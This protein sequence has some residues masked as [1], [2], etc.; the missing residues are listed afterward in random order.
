MAFNFTNKLPVFLFAGLILGIFLLPP[1]ARPDGDTVYSVEVWK[2]E[3]RDGAFRTFD[4]LVSWLPPEK[5]DHLRIEL[6]RGTF[7]L[8]VGK[9]T[10]KFQA[11]ELIAIVA[12]RY[13]SA[14]L[15]RTRY[16]RSRLVKLYRTSHDAPVGAGLP[17]TATRKE[18]KP[19]NLPPVAQTP[20]PSPPDTKTEKTLSPPSPVAHP[21]ATVFEEPEKEKMLA[22]QPQKSP[23]APAPPITQV[24]SPAK[25]QEKPLPPVAS[26]P[27]ESV[28]N[29][30][31]PSPEQK[32]FTVQA[33]SFTT[34]K[35]AKKYYG[36][37]EWHLPPAQRKFLRIERVKGYITVRVGCFA[38]ES[39][40]IPLL[41]RVRELEKTSHIL[42][43]HILENRI[44][45]LYREP[46]L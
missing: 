5:R 34:M 10:E 35:Q 44:E 40:A 19:E 17:G 4:T 14:T 16:D 25:P 32:I 13:S 7:A 23:S 20:P 27:E 42:S 3:T 9:F 39:A 29:P 15:V 18:L 26:L 28:P 30:E 22:A 24:L 31:L 41:N 45:Q 37:L 8:R 21:P 1:T 12:E 33:G 11:E 6:V 38:T 43:T 36:D 46:Q 2:F